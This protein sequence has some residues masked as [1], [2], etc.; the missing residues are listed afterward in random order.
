MNP[1]NLFRV[2]LWQEEC[3]H[4]PCIHVLKGLICGLLP[5][6]MEYGVLLNSISTLFGK[7]FENINM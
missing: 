4:K 7:Q 6:E 5:I 2:I 1:L 3:S